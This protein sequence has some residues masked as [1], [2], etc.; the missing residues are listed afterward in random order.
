MGDVA[1]IY[2]RY[3][4]HGDGL[5]CHIVD[6]LRV[7]VFVHRRRGVGDVGSPGAEDD[8]RSRLLQVGVSVSDRIQVDLQHDRDLEVQIGDKVALKLNKVKAKL[9]VRDDLATMPFSDDDERDAVEEQLFREIDEGD[10]DNE[11]TKTL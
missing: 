7:A 10:D 1:G 3:I 4:C 9:K 6:T 2:A 8:N 5:L 11:N